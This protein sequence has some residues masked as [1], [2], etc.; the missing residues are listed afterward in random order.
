MAR[1]FMQFGVGQLEE[2]FANSKS[3]TNVLKQL[4]HELTYRQVPRAVALLAKVRAAMHGGKDGTALAPAALPDDL[5][6]SPPSHQ[7]GSGPAIAPARAAITATTATANSS[8]GDAPP[9]TVEDAYE[10]LKVTPGAT[11]ES[12]ENSRRQLVQQSHPDRVASLSVA[13]RDQ[14]MAE[15]KRVNTVYAILSQAR[16]NRR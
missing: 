15:A 3:D 2:L 7:A 5:A 4:E 13:R 12:I 8:L 10:V 11:W 16:R 6:L 1:R 9:I 14:V